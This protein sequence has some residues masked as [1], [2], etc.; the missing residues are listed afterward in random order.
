MIETVPSNR[1]MLEAAARMVGATP[2]IGSHI[3]VSP[4]SR[5]SVAAF[6]QAKLSDYAEI[7]RPR[8]VLVVVITT[9]AGFLTTAG[10]VDLVHIVFLSAGV[11]LVAAAATALNQVLERVQDARMYRTRR[12]PLAQGNLHPENAIWF[13]GITCVTGLALL[14]IFSLA[15]AA[16][17]LLALLSYDFVY[18]PLKRVSSWSLYVGAI[19]GA[20]PPLIGSI[21]AEKHVSLAGLT[22]FGFLFIW[23][24]PHFLAIGWL[25]REDY[26]RAGF[27]VLAVEDSQASNS[28][29]IALISSSVLFLIAFCLAGAGYWSPLQLVVSGISIVVV[30]FYAHQLL[31]TPTRASA[32]KLFMASNISLLL[33]M[34][35]LII[36]SLFRFST[37]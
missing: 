37:S 32:K 24:I 6:P 12:R 9:L 4:S 22:L 31:T 20:L 1:S 23:Q 8:I 34:M 14:A 3:G 35:I 33:T 7:T 30:M 36:P 10:R 28:A 11:S 19:P 13:A 16:A 17:A 2:P 25:H 27:H 21:F 26:K 5:G 15:S 29:T 18:T